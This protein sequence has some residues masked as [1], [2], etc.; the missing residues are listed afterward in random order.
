V[1]EGAEKVRSEE[2]GV[3]SEGGGAQNWEA[4][5]FEFCQRLP[6]LAMTGSGK[7]HLFRALYLLWCLYPSTVI[8]SGGKRRNEGKCKNRM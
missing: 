5:P 3:R 1:A 4:P 8:S 2:L 7:R 6:P